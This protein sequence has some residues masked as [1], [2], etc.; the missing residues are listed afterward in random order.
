MLSPVDGVV[1]PQ[2]VE[3]SVTTTYPADTSVVFEVATTDEWPSVLASDS[4]LTD[5][6]GNASFAPDLGLLSGQTAHLQW[7]AM[8][9][10]E[11]YSEWSEYE[12]FYVSHLPAGVPA[13]SA[14]QY[15]ESGNRM[16]R[17]DVTWGEAADPDYA[18]ITGYRVTL[19]P[20]D[21]V[22]VP[23]NCYEY[24]FSGCHVAFEG[25]ALGEYEVT[26]VAL[27]QLGESAADVVPVSIVSYISSAP[28]GLEVAVELTDAEVSW[29]VPADLGGEQVDHYHYTL[30]SGCDE[31]SISDDTVALSVSFDDLVEACT[32]FFEVRAVTDAGSGQAAYADFT[33]YGLP[34]EESA[35]SAVQA[36]TD[37]IDLTWDSAFDNG[38]PVSGYVVTIS[39][40]DD[41][42][43]VT[44]GDPWFRQGTR[45]EGLDDGVAYSFT[46]EAV[47]RAGNGASVAFGPFTLV[48]GELDQDGD[49]LVDAGEVRVG[50]SP[51]LADTDGDGLSDFEELTNLAG[52]ADPVLVD[53]DD[54]GV[55]DGLEDSD[56][57]GMSDAVEVAG[58]T[59]PLDA[60]SDRD[61][62]DD[63]VESTAGSDP[64][65]PDSDHD[66][67]QDGAE[68]SFGMDPL[69][70]DS[71]GDAELDGDELTSRTLEG[72]PSV[73][74]SA[75]AE[76]SGAA[77]QLQSAVIQLAELT[78]IPGIIT[79]ATTVR[80][81]AEPEESAG[82]SAR[83]ASLGS[84]IDSIELSYPSYVTAALADL[85]PIRWN[86][87]L[88][89]WEFADN[90]VSLS[91]A[92]HTI[93]VYSPELGV[94]YAVVDLREWRGNANQCTSAEQGHP[95]LDVE[96][97]LDMTS[98]MENADPTGE[99]FDALRT[100][101]GSLQPGDRV[102]L[103]LFGIMGV[104]ARGDANY[105]EPITWPVV[106][107]RLD[108]RYGIYG[109]DEF[110][111]VSP[112]AAISM[113]DEIEARSAELST[114]D[115]SDLFGDP[116]TN[117]EF[118]ERAMGG[119]FNHYIWGE[120]IDYESR[121]RFLNDPAKCRLHTVLLATDGAARP[122]SVAGD[123]WWAPSGYVYFPDRTD[124]VHVLDVGAGTPATAGWLEDLA[125]DTGG[126]YSYVPTAS[127][128]AS[129]I[130]DVIPYGWAPPAGPEDDWDDDG[131]PDN[132]E[133]R[134]VVAVFAD[135]RSP[136]SKRLTSDPYDADTDGDSLEDGVEVGQ[137]AMAGMLGLASNDSSA[138]YIVR[139]SPRSWDGDDDGLGDLEE[140]E[141]GYNALDH[142]QDFDD[143]DDGEEVT[144]GTSPRDH[145][146]DGD[147]FPDGFEI[148]AVD[149][150]FHP[151]E[152]DQHVSEWVWLEDISQ[153]LICGDFCPGDSVGWLIGS[154]ISGYLILGDIRD[155]V[156]GSIN[157]QWVTV[158][159]TAVGLIPAVG[160][161][162]RTINVVKK[163]LLRVTDPG[164][165]K[166][167]L[168]AIS[169]GL[170]DLEGLRL[171]DEVAPG[172]KATL[173]A[174]GA[175]PAGIRFLMDTIGI[176]HLKALA[177]YAYRVAP[178]KADPGVA[179]RIID[180]PRFWL[181][182][183]A[184]EKHVI[185]ELWGEVQHA[186]T[187]ANFPGIVGTRY[188]DFVDD[189]DFFE[190]KTGVAKFRSI[191]RQL[192]YDVEAASDNDITYVLLAS[193]R[194]GIGPD[195]M[196]L[197]LLEDAGVPIQIYWP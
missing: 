16:N 152:W 161:V 130:N 156:A 33:A 145:D 98:S 4:V 9:Q 57:D 59:S 66:G 65:D 117:A 113:I 22:Q 108:P 103:R 45:L 23:A 176:D 149:R 97:I 136:Q 93:T 10:G 40:G 2:P 125:D 193:R 121:N 29:S 21:V 28:S 166:A 5:S 174:E 144:W 196:A 75:R 128:V 99:R 194:T 160:D 53:T 158:S 135:W 159:F 87:A 11:G 85:Q 68:A 96:L 49:G 67:L 127:D 107:E 50:T 80:V 91:T 60:D 48:D 89:T 83:S 169:P 132:V 18:P 195:P 14:V 143:V 122:S 190:I 112:A 63:S 36:D 126:S 148:D 24:E 191:S 55:A 154:L 192:A 116:D 31:N 46:V 111:A 30:N 140:L 133:V 162:A 186:K 84:A 3:L 44:A 72:D 109:E 47:N 173:V 82:A 1:V 43:E 177:N 187:A 79:T 86:E 110:R 102:S 12:D 180:E 70:A 88:G 26:V 34:G 115:E 13:V 131:L 20:G 38:D 137:L 101:L 39:P 73:A 189:P 54:D 51:I 123:A 184:G 138:G 104:Y 157:G 183:R 81:V 167:A 61:G 182:G 95:R 42:V 19:D 94:Q 147:G 114:A 181:T 179:V 188:Y 7:R 172:L 71:D 15:D 100:V 163:F 106:P 56:S 62:L 141:L 74:L 77:S 120:H 139:S 134:G 58:G 197:N 6:N 151:S 129:W 171:L 175:T 155:I 153:G 105:Y 32:Y 52:I 90:D 178:T 146:S 76:L 64:L 35:I 17:I 185:E 25:L 27:N 119:V 92:T 8:V 118:I 69:D 170:D 168:D 164:V 78:D 124:P 37:A 142:D 150:G 165:R 41:E